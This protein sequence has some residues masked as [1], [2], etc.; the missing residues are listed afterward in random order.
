MT[1]SAYEREIMED[2]ASVS[3]GKANGK[4]NGHAGP[5]KVDNVT[6]NWRDHS[7]TAA[8]LQRETFPPVS[9]C[10][11][12]LIPEGLTIIAGKPKIGKKA[13]WRSIS[14]SPSRPAVTAWAN[15]SRLRATCSMPPWRTI[16]GDCSAA[17]IACCRQ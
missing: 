5:N 4:A 1:M 13:G 7:F 9:Y 12:D 11:P 6:F 3:G 8:K 16:H 2:V 15:A 17:S 14:A 10:V